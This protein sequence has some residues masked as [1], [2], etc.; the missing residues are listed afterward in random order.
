MEKKLQKNISYILQFIKKY[1]ETLLPEKEDV[2][3][4]LS[5]KGTT[6]ADYMDAV[7]V[8][9]MVRWSQMSSNIITCHHTSWL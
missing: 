5:M 9:D 2:S 3:S 4:H 1:H 8:S 7:V 6:D